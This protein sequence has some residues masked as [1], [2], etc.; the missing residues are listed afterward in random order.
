MIRGRTIALRPIRESDLDALLEIEN[1]HDRRGPWV[2]HRL[3][4]RPAFEKEFRETGFLTADSGKLLIVD[5]EDRLLGNIGFF[6]PAH[7]MD[8]LELGYQIFDTAQRGRG[9]TTEAVRLLVDWLFGVKKIGR[10]QLGIVPENVPSRRVA[11]KS[12]FQYEGLLRSAVYL[13]GV[14][15]DLEIWGLLR[16]EWEERRRGEHSRVK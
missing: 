9:V 1:D 16:R 7:Y 10:L 2:I 6:K 13:D 14:S 11:E 15:R 3:T 4:A 12:G 8:A 5:A